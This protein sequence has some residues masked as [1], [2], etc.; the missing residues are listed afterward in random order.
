[1]EEEINSKQ[2]KD[3]SMEELIFELAHDGVEYIRRDAEDLL[4]YRRQINKSSKVQR[5]TFK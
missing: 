5:S 1:M 3:E 2:R 4:G